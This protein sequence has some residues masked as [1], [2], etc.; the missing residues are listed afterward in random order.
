MSKFYTSFLFILFF[1]VS[2][3]AGAI[4]F[5]LHNHTI[6]FSSL[7]QDAHAKPSILL[8]QHGQEWGRF[9]LD[10]RKY[11][12]LEAMPV[13]LVQAFL[14]TEDRTFFEHP[15][16]SFRGILRS[17]LVNLYSGKKVQGAS[18]ITQQLVR[19]LFFESKKT[20]SRKLKEQI[21]AI[22]VERQWSKEQILE[23]YL[24]NVYFGYGIYGV[25]AA[26]QRFW[27]KD[28]ADISLDQAC[29][30]ASIMKSPHKYSPIHAVQKVTKRRNMILN[31]MKTHDMISREQFLQAIDAS[32]VIKDPET[33]LLAPHLK[34]TIRIFLENLFGRQMLYTGGLTIQTTIDIGM[35]QASQQA[36]AAHIAKLRSC[37]HE[38][39]DGGLISL[40]SKTGQIRAMIGGYDFKKSKFNRALQ[41]YRQMGSIFKVFVYAA[42][43]EHGLKMS[44][45]DIDEPLEM[46]Q[47]GM[48]W[49]PGNYNDK[50]LG[51]MTHAYALS[52]SNNILSIKALLNVGV[53]QV[54]EMAQ[55]CHIVSPMKPYP[56]LAL[57]CV[58]GTL[59]EM[60]GSFNVMVNHGK[61]VQPYFISWVKNLLGQKIYKA[62]T[63]QEQVLD[64]AIAGCIARVLTFGIERLK[65]LNNSPWFGGDAL[66]K[67]GTTNDSRTCW[68]CGATPELTT[69][70]YIGCDGNESLGHNVYGSRTAFPI[71]FQFH[72]KIAKA[73]TTFYYDPK[74]RERSIHWITGQPSQDFSNP[75]VVTLLE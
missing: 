51:P 67:T 61:Y 54:I 24:N 46:V 71:W 38:N 63:C 44:D 62:K 65:N 50:F 7:Q 26:A 33:N 49:S 13:H 59:L 10:K 73:P 47:N 5:F 14:V 74:L 17:M 56:S 41:A 48:L 3:S 18:T 42:A 75:D 60:V 29:V 1:V 6:D 40:D 19:L 55:R 45:V 22:L 52:H 35:Q 4:C 32:I 21:Y 25:Q 27:G 11:V 64:S 53:H 12:L 37:L 58:D 34:E 72:E 36:F 31:M 69:A 8:D 43:L 9:Q 15:G 57:G 23:A 20:F 16:I 70:I 28:I 39:I 30:L 66:G 2:L 68:F